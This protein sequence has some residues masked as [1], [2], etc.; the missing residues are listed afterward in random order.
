MKLNSRI[1]SP[2]GAERRVEQREQGMAPRRKAKGKGKRKNARWQFAALP[3]IVGD[4]GT[5][6]M[7]VTSRDSGRWVLPKGWEKKRLSAPDL[8]ALEAFE[9][10]GLL[11]EIATD[12]IG[13]YS[14]SKGM[15]DGTA[16]RCDVR[17]FA[18]RVAEL[19]DDWP[20]RAERQ[21]RWFTLA[22]A[23]QQVEERDLMVLLL[24][25]VAEKYQP[26]SA[27]KSAPP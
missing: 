22:E 11:G 27:P 10:A 16:V 21:R 3:W 26:A 23:A 8:A 4:A 14:Y 6:V 9:E 7:L 24:G 17:V 1:N 18:M 20:E 19:L 13:F 12:P 2:A 5:L 25:F 15:P